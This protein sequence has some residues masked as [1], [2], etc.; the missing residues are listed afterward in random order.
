MMRILNA[1]LALVICA[2]FAGRAVAQWTFFDLD[3]ALSG[4]EISLD[5]SAD[6]DAGCCCDDED[7]DE[8]DSADDCCADECD[9]FSCPMKMDPVAPGQNLTPADI[10]FPGQPLLFEVSAPPAGDWQFGLER[11]PRLA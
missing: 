1:I 7:T 6:N 3:D 8:D 5:S 11:P 2:A 4:A 9:H 10:S